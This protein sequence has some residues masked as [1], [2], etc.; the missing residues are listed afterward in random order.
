M[1]SNSKILKNPSL[2]DNQQTCLD[3]YFSVTSNVATLLP[4]GDA[5]AGTSLVHGYSAAAPLTTAAIDTFTGNT[6]DILGDT[7]F[8]ATAMGTDSMG[9]VIDMGGQAEKAIALIAVLYDTV[10]LGTAVAGVSTALTNSLSTALSCSTLGNLYGR[11][12]VSGFDA[13]SAKILHLKVICKLK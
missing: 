9:F 12:V 2:Q 5:G 4:S 7:C 6:N 8:A 11:V 10:T 13:A 1:A 3:F